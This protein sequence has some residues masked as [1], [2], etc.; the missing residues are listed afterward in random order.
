MTE[1]V[2]DHILKNRGI[3]IHFY[4]FSA[5]KKTIKENEKWLKIIQLWTF[6]SKISITLIIYK[7]NVC[8]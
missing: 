1:S 8:F 2:F 7:E 6:G 5:F 3:L 4:S